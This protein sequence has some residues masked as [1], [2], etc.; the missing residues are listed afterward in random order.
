[1]LSRNSN[2]GQAVKLQLKFPAKKDRDCRHRW[3]DIQLNNDN[4][5]SQVG[6]RKKWASRIR[7]RRKKATTLFTHRNFLFDKLNVL[8][9]IRL[10]FHMTSPK[11]QTKKPSILLSF[12]VS[13]GITTPKHLYLNKVLVRKGASFEEQRTFEYLG[14]SV[15]R[16]LASGRV[17]SYV[18]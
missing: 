1:M 7:S 11:T 15:T 6:T 13:W 10:G 9:R 8:S 17:G 14:F 3:A 16:H 12:W 18:G 5:H 2:L 4:G